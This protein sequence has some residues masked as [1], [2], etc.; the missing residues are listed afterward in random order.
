MS[1]NAHET[2]AT[3]SVITATYNA[4]THLPKLIESLRGQ[5]DKDFEWVVADGASDDG[6]LELLRSVTGINIVISSQADFGIYDALN[7]AI[8]ASSGE[9]YIV[10][11]A[12]DFFYSDAIANFRRA[13]VQS[14]ADIIV[15][16]AMYGQRRVK[17]RKGPVWLFGGGALISAHTLATSFKKDLHR[18]Y[19]FYSKKYP[20]AA[21]YFFVMQACKGGAR[22]YETDFVAGEIGRAGVSSVDRIGG[23]LEV[24]RVQLAVGNSFLVQFLLLALRFLRI[25]ILKRRR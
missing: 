20:I 4:A 3:I 2:R 22:R 23:A 12:D 25:M 14:R 17:V 13:I 8:K 19:G 9:Y 16:D 5:T 10:C 1:N 7:R 6:T 18:V 21:D 15:A 24:F 11:G